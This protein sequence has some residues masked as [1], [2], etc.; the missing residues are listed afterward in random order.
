MKFNLSDSIPSVTGEPITMGDKPFTLRDALQQA[1]STD[2]VHEVGQAAGQVRPL[3]AVEIAHR[4]KLL[5]LASGSDEIEMTVEEVAQVK[6]LIR[7]TLRSAV[8][9]PVCSALDGL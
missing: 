8:A 3:S 2:V 9:V 1:I 7:S 5:R 6:D 4:V